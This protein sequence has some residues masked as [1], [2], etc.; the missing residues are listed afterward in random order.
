VLAGVHSAAEEL[1]AG[2]QES[3]HPR[4]GALAVNSKSPAIQ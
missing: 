2:R 1:G 4:N 3:A